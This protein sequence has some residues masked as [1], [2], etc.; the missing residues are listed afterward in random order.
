MSLSWEGN[1]EDGYIAKAPFNTLYSVYKIND[2]W[3]AY[4]IINGNQQILLGTEN[5]KSSISKLICEADIITEMEL[6][7]WTS[8]K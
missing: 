6:Y 1:E 7:G 3:F 2:K 4:L 5:N 8:L